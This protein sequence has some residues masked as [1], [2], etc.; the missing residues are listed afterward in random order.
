MTTATPVAVRNSVRSTIVSS[1]YSRWVSATDTG[2][3][4]QN[5]PGSPRI[6]ANTAGESNA[7]R[8]AQSMDPARLT[9]AE[10]WQFD[11]RA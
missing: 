1:T 4:D 9:S 2:V 7:G 3:I 5:P 8:H 10:P 6:R 11:N